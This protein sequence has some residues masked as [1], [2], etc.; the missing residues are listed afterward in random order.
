MT[1]RLQVSF[2]L[3]CGVGAGE[4]SEIFAGWSTIGVAFQYQFMREFPL[5]PLGRHNVWF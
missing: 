4:N 5:C 1:K 2:D 3:P